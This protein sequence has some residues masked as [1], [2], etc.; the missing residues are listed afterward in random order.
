MADNYQ[1][2]LQPSHRSFARSSEKYI[3][4][5]VAISFE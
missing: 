1:P 2:T 3:S 5:F 4:P